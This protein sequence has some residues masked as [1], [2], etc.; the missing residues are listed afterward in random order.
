[1]TNEWHT[2]LFT[3]D[4]VE[5]GEIAHWLNGLE[6]DANTNMT[7]AEHI[8][9]VGERIFANSLREDVEHLARERKFTSGLF[10]QA[11]A[12]RDRALTEVERLRAALE[13][14]EWDNEYYCP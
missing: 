12:E 3:F 14:V 10:I 4:D 7:F 9:P 1:M 2:R 6:N 5:A 11:A 8:I 13:A